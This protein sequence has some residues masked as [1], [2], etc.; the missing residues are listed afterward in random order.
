MRP[1][2]PDPAYAEA[3]MCSSPQSRESVEKPHDLSQYYTGLVYPAGERV[4][5]SA[6]PR[7]FHPAP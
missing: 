4:C 1:A 7:E 5:R 6:T 3:D 2:M